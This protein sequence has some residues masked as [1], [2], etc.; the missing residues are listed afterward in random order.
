MATGSNTLG[1]IAR[2]V[3]LRVPTLRSLGLD[4]IV[5]DLA[6]AAG[7]HRP[8]AAIGR[9]AGGVGRQGFRHR[10]LGDDGHR[11]GRAV[12]GVSGRIFRRHHRRVLPADRPCGPRQQGGVGNRDHRRAG[13]GAHADRRADRLHVGRQRLSDRRARRRSCRCRSCIA[14]ARS[15]TSW[16]REGLG[17]GRVIARPFVG[18]PAASRGRPT[19]T[20][21]RCRRAARRCSIASR[22]PG[23]RSWRS[24][25][26]RIC[27]PAAA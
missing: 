6:A 11:A 7:A 15:P 20:T 1:N 3:P 8:L 21:T 24:A 27:L 14:R 17:V 26:S 23:S 10:P 5:V 19:A 12:P 18:R 2:E 16:W 22:P 13:P 25:R 9:M 4:R